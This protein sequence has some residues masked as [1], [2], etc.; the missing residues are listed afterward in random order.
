MAECCLVVELPQGEYG[1]EVATVSWSE[2][3]VFSIEYLN[4]SKAATFRILAI[5]ELN[6]F[7][8]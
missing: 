2:D 7:I 5:C 8:N 6:R 3:Q 1:T 4:N